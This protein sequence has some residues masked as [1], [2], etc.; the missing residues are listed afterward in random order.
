VDRSCSFGEMVDYIYGPGLLQRRP[1]NPST[2]ELT[3]SFVPSQ[4]FRETIEAVRRSST[5]KCRFQCS[6]PTCPLT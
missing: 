1:L 5:S 6:S 3:F 4:V 2:V